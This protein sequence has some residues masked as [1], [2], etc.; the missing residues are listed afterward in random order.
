VP[1]LSLVQR[2]PT[3][4][5]LS[6]CDREASIMMRPWPAKGC[7]AMGEGNT[8]LQCRTNDLLRIKYR[9]QLS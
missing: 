1:G 3:V 4:C 5:G 2:S 9:F 7:C 6:E 8:V